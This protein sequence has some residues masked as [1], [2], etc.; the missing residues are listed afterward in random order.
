MDL[1]TV[2][3]SWSKGGGANASGLAG[4]QREEIEPAGKEWENRRGKGKDRRP[5]PGYVRALVSSRG[6]VT[7]VSPHTPKLVV[8]VSRSALSNDPA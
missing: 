2:V 4:Q 6:I 8:V 7:N 1:V 3:I 5:G